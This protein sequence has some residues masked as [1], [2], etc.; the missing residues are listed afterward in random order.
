MTIRAWWS[1]QSEDQQVDIPQQ[2]KGGHIRAE[3]N[4]DLAFGSTV[5]DSNPAPLVRHD[6]PATAVRWEV[7]MN[8]NIDTCEVFK[9]NHPA[10]KHSLSLLNVLHLYQ[11]Q[12]MDVRQMRST[13]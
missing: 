1:P 8:L 11:A 2:K 9:P 10:T 12:E 6:V 13:Q 7:L 4:K 5:E 3:A